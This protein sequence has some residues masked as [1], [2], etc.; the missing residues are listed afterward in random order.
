MKHPIIS[1]VYKGWSDIGSRGTDWVG[2][3][4]SALYRQVLEMVQPGA[5]YFFLFD[6]FLKHID[7]V[8][9]GI[10]EVIGVPADEF[11]VQYIMD[12]MHPEDLPLFGDI[13]ATVVEF[14]KKLALEDLFSYKTRYNYRM[15]KQDGDFVHILQQTITIAADD[16]GNVMRNLVLHT[17]IT[18]IAPFQEM[19]L[20]FIGLKGLPSYINVR[21]ARRFSVEKL[22][23]TSSELGILGLLVEGMDSKRIAQIT[24]RSLHTIR[25]HR[26]NIL[27]KTGCRSIQELLIRSLKEGWI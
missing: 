25:T 19:R 6:P 8:S 26:K 11:S 20:S 15:R 2:K 16:S 24:N 4:D 13:E 3:L 5:S 18:D 17:D 7:M 10:Q 9:N 22:Q 14:K 23:L 12:N 21:P 1:E 27:R